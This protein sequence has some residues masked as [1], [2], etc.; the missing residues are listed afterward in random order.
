MRWMACLLVLLACSASAQE[1]P[2]YRALRASRPDGRTIAVKDLTLERD[3]Y[4]I[5]FRSGTVH[6]LAPVGRDTVAAVF[7]GDGSYQLTPATDTERR[8][9]QLVTNRADVLS[10]RFTRLILLF[11]DQTAAE[12][13][14]HAP[15]A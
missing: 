7:I 11:T 9:L 5:T 6:L 12:V 13:Q 10:D 15:V 2:E 8:H 3:A 4:R 14:M 1:A